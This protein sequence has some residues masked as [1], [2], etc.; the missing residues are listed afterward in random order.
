M[1]AWFI[2]HRWIG[3]P[4]WLLLGFIALT[5]TIATVSH[6]LSW[7]AN[8]ALRA[9]APSA[10]A[11]PLPLPELVQHVEHALPEASLSWGARFEPYMA[12]V[13]SVNRPDQPP[14]LAYVN[15]YTGAIQ[16]LN[17]S[18]FNFVQFIRALHGWLMYPWHG[19]YS[20]GYY[21][22]GAMSLVL[23]MALLSGL[24]IYRR[25]WV[26]LLKPVIRLGRGRRALI[27]DLHKITG[28]WSIWFFLAIGLTGLWFLVQGIL[29]H[30]DVEV[31]AHPEPQTVAQLLSLPNSDKATAPPKASLQQMVDRAEA[32]HRHKTGH[33]FDWHYVT[34]PAANTEPMM[35]LG[36]SAGSVLF[37]DYS[38]RYFLD[39]YTGRIEQAVL[40]QDMNGLE[41]VA[42]I[43]D[44]IHFGRLGGL[45]TKALWVVFGL[46]M[47]GMFFTGFLMT[48]RRISSALNGR[49]ATGPNVSAPRRFLPWWSVGYGAV[50]FV[51]SGYFL[52]A[53]SG[54]PSEM[55]LDLPDTDL[56]LSRATIATQSGVGHDSERTHDIRL[57]M[58]IEDQQRVAVAYASLGK[59][60]DGDTYRGE[61][62]LLHGHGERLEAHAPCLDGAAHPDLYFSIHYWSGR[63][64]TIRIPLKAGN[65]CS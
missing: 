54:S 46:L 18:G 32:A 29:W 8:P 10:D 17:D 19:H 33:V 48:R 43:A 38:A 12:T 27:A 28:V 6:E 14:A 15:P 34:F 4:I 55:T 45:W 37:D 42:H 5:G 50:F 35:L 3:L 24:M 9:N 64:Q 16:Q 1:R 23:L 63:E 44:P 31:D 56:P 57:T 30:N 40:P 36:T 2:L 62:G 7:L 53:G 52:L 22:V 11:R 39:P 60:I 47:T 13:F 59:P 21:L 41:T 26:A 49:T 61:D 65:W 20:Y 58:P 25:F 51:L